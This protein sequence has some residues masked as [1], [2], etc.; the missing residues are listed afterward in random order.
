MKQQSNQTVKVSTA[1]IARRND[2]FLVALR[3]PGTSIGEAWEFPGGKKEYSE[4]SQQ[5]LKR[6]FREEFS[7]DIIVGELICTESFI[8]RDQHYELQVYK[9]RLINEA[10]VLQEH[11]EVKWV[12]LYD[13]KH[14][15]M[16][17][18]DKKIVRCLENLY[19]AGE[20]V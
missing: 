13:L 20:L 8:N 10:F 9:V 18:S 2:K 7:I 15:P 16:A 1:G 3:R 14:L 19:L 12:S 4:S 11:Q 6:E 5:A 17:S